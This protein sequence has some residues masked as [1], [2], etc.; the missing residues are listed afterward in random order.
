VLAYAPPWFVAKSYGAIPSPLVGLNTKDNGGAIAYATLY[1]FTHGELYDGPGGGLAMFKPEKRDAVKAIFTSQCDLGPQMAS[2]GATPSDFYDEAFVTSVGNCA[3]AD[4]AC[5]TDPAKTWEARF[6]VDRPTI[7]ATQAPIVI[8]QGGNDPTVPKD[9][10]ACGVDK[11]NADLAAAGASA[12]WKLTT[13]GDT[14]ADHG[15]VVK[16]NTEW[17]L[18]WIAAHAKGTAQP[19]CPGWDT[20]GSPVCAT[21]PSNTD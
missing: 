7:D 16:D 2:L 9:R 18:Q 10:V 6:K 8:W 20:I 21:P 14:A 12:T 4:A 17:A 15:G 3:V 1:F 19:T 13:C 11:I 5:D